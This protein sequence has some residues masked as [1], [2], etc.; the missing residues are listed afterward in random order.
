MSNAIVFPKNTVMISSGDLRS[1]RRTTTA[2][3]RSE[4]VGRQESSQYLVIAES[5]E[6]AVVLR[7]A[8]PYNVGYVMLL[9]DSY[10]PS[11]VNLHDLRVVCVAAQTVVVENKANPKL[12]SNA[13][14]GPAVRYLM[15]ALLT[16]EDAG[17]EL[18]AV[19]VEVDT[20]RRSPR[21]TV[22]LAGQ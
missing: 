16:T 6:E 3:V 22:L 14:F 17:G 15:E 19:F 10:L 5:E 8:A 9:S 4:H 21:N 11:G 20:Q 2:L 1:R 18:P 12:R 13:P 7:E